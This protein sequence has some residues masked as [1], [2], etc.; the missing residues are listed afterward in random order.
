MGEL[1]VADEIELLVVGGEVV[2]PGPD[3]LVVERLDVAVAGG[4]VVGLL[5]PGDP[6]PARVAKELSARGCLVLPGLVNAHSHSYGMLG[7]AQADMLPL[8]PWMVYAA[9]ITANRTE[10]EVALAATLSCVELVRSG[11]TT[12]LDHLGGQVSGLGAAAQAYVDFGMRAV[13][14]PMIGDL[15]LHHTVELGDAQWPAGLW[16]DLE[17]VPVP[18]AAALLDETRELLGSWHGRHE[19]IRI[20]VG[21]SGPQR[22]SDELLRGCAEVAAEFGTGVHTHLLETRNQAAV[23]RQ[24]F[25]TS[26]VEHLDRLGLVNERFMG[27]HGVWCSEDELRLLGERGASLVHNPWSNLYLGGGVAPLVAWRR[28]GVRVAIGTDGANCGCDLSMPIAMRLAAT[29]HRAQGKVD[30]DEWPTPAEILTAATAGNAAA[31]GWADEIGTVEVGRAADL[32]VVDATGTAYVPRH[33]PVAQLV[34]GE[35]GANVRHTVIAGDV[36]MEDRVVAAVDERELLAEAQEVATALRRRND[37]LFRAA[38][39]QA[40]VLA[41]ASV[42]APVPAGWPAPPT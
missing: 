18:S 33:D 10:R 37:E 23:T 20:F 30:R 17:R 24:R 2:R 39:R 6:R 13:V 27:A 5:G 11:T 31:L 7:R 9:A 25:G 38:D 15:P 16:E 12:V 40:D 26:A 14:A 19:R 3:G 42:S 4:R 34:Y 29:L 35:T 22:C 41:R 8:E 1:D 36:V 32:A 28:N 21:P